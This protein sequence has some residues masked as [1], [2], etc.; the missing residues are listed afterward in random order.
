MRG[1]SAEGARLHLPSQTECALSLRRK[2]GRR[3]VVHTAV[4]WASR[5][6][7]RDNRKDCDR[8]TDWDGQQ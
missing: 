7:L 2:R 1:E 4:Y 8:N 5:R 6:K 3:G